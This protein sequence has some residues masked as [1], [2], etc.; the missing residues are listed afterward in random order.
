M[1]Q[2][3]KRKLNRPNQ[4]CAHRAF[5]PRATE[6]KFRALRQFARIP[7]VEYLARG[8]GS[9]Q[10]QMSGISTPNTHDPTISN[11]QFAVTHHVF[12]MRHILAQKILKTSRMPATWIAGIQLQVDRAETTRIPTVPQPIKHVS[13]ELG[14]KWTRKSTWQGTAYRV[15]SLLAMLDRYE[16]HDNTP[17]PYAFANPTSLRGSFTSFHPSGGPPSSPTYPHSIALQ[18]THD[19]CLNTRRVKSRLE[20]PPMLICPG[21]IVGADEFL[22]T[23]QLFAANR[24]QGSLRTETLTIWVWPE[25]A[26]PGVER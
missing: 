15:M 19:I 7:R 18:L 17:T 8:D 5:P 6:L 12:K 21:V 23:G 16:L 20:G 4:P 14:G 9:Q 1:P 11:A 3:A 24:E 13:V 2:S 26:E 10:R 25:R 22:M